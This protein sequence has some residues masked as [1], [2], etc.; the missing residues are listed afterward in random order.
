M[1]GKKVNAEYKRFLKTKEIKSKEAGFDIDKFELNDNLFDWQKDVVRWA[2]RKGKAC[3]FEDCGLGKTIQQ[4][5]FAHQVSLHTDEPVLIISP[6]AVAIQTVNEGKRFGF[7]VNICRT[8]ND[9]KSGIN[10]TNYEMLHHFTNEFA[11]VVLDESSILKSKDGKTRKMITDM[12]R[13]VKY[14]LCCTATPAP[15]DFTEIGEHSEFLGVMSQAE[16]LATFFVHDGGSTSD[17]R[18]K[19]HA[20]EK[21]FAWVASWA[22]CLTNP[23]DLGYDGKNYVLPELRIHEITVASNDLEDGDGQMMM[24]PKMSLGLSERRA[25]R[26]DSIE[27]RVKAA[28]DIANSFDDQVLIWCDLN[29]ESELLSKSITGCVE[30]KGSDTDEHKKSSMINFSKGDV[31]ALVSK[32]KIAGWG[33][34]WQNCHN[35]IFVGL[36]DSF[37]SYY[38]AVRRCWRFGQKNPVDVYIIISEKEGAVKQNIERKQQESQYMTSE[39]VEY[40]KDILKSDIK[41][42]IRMTENYIATER[43]IIPS[44]L[45]GGA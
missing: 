19:G 45:K 11:G 42:T 12:F 32:P 5:S 40:T 22:C 24:I 27:N 23:S 30:V 26:S 6:L 15:N 34:N 16:M 39:L 29:K 13:D 17:W 44:W 21:F 25:A 33:M 10:I 43:M 31:R 3:L 1:G 9:V 35:I 4:L 2:L 28:A 8:Q 38:Q 41:S 7:D 18:L 36:S 37:E 20:K 14:K